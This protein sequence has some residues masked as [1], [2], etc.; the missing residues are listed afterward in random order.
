MAAVIFSSK[1]VFWCLIHGLKELLYLPSTQARF[2][3]NFPDKRLVTETTIKLSKCLPKI[4]G[5]YLCVSCYKVR[6]LADI[7]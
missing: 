1:K 7:S 5:I 4:K 6:K 3:N 2:G